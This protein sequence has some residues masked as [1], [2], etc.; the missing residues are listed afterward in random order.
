VCDPLLSLL[1]PLRMP[2]PFYLIYYL[3]EFAIFLPR[4]EKKTLTLQ[5]VTLF[6]PI[7]YLRGFFKPSPLNLYNFTQ[8]Q[9]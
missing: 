5:D 1:C 2:V 7:N 4:G 6:T 8:K 3:K 9:R